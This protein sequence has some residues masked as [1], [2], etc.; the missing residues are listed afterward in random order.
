MNL[1]RITGLAVLSLLGLSA[2]QANAQFVP[3][4]GYQRGVTYSGAT[5]T[6]FGVSQ[7]FT[8]AN[9]WL[10]QVVDNQTYVNHWTGVAYQRQ[11]F[12]NPY[13][14]WATTRAY[15]PWF[16]PVLDTRYAN[17]GPI[18][19]ANYLTPYSAD[20]YSRFGR[21]RPGFIIGR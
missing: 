4:W 10:R 3:G 21:Y 13:G 5:I 2:T 1:Q 19:P 14:T 18:V 16:G 9:P 6:P 15:N 11:Y 17:Y 20:V 12:S 8:S 7:R